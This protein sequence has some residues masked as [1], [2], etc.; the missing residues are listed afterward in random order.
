MSH[1]LQFIPLH[2]TAARELKKEMAAISREIARRGGP[3]GTEPPDS[4]AM[5][6]AEREKER[7]RAIKTIPKP[8]LLAA[9]PGPW[10]SQVI[11]VCFPPIRNSKD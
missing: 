10:M 3:G 11:F 8:E 9:G 1:L 6:I 7:Q 4:W 2:T 5:R